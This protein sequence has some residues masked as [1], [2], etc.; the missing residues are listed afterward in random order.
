MARAESWSNVLAFT[1]D[2]QSSEE[3]IDTHVWSSLM[4]R[5]LS[6]AERRCLINIDRTPNILLPSMPLLRT[7]AL[8]QS[9]SPAW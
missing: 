2:V 3:E 6:A 7:P 4:V 9:S 5:V 8:S 1:W